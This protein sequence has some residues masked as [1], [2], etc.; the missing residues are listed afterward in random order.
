MPAKNS[1][2]LIDKA[3]RNGFGTIVDPG[4]SGTISP[5]VASY[6]NI[7][8]VTTAGAESRAL[9]AASG[10]PP[11]TRMYVILNTDG[12]DLSITGSADGTIVLDDAGEVA[13]FIVS[14]AGTTNEWRRLLA[15][16]VD[17]TLDSV[18]LG[19]NDPINF[20]DADDISIAW[21]ATLLAITQAAANSAIDMGVDGAG[22]DVIFRGDTAGVSMTWDQS[23]DSLI[24]TDN[25]KAVFGT[26]SDIAITWNATNL[27]ITQAAAN[28]SI[29]MGV[30]GAG[31]DVIFRGDTAGVSMTWDQSADSLILTDN[32]KVVF[33]TGSDIAIA[34]N[35]TNLAITQAAANSSIDLGVDGAGIDVIF[36]GDTASQSLT[37][38]QSADDLVMTSAVQ[39]TGAGSTVVPVVPAAAAIQALI[40]DGDITITQFLTTADTTAATITSALP[41]G[42]QAGQLKKTT[43]VVDGGNDWV[44]TPDSMSGGTSATFADVGDFILWQWT[45]AAWLAIDKGN[46]ATGDD[47]PVIA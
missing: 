23:A 31:I 27:A 43:L 47:G 34:W 42:A 11:Y 35:G 20:G 39:I 24:F 5:S 7:C 14:R 19:D 9:P 28:S 30:D 45:G 29:D 1:L 32:G 22:I 17:L 33:G 13:E 8:E 44:I 40:A 6:I 25:G 12:G 38:D 36:R 41:N 10:F 46:M 26:G 21:N 37:W 2:F 18:S 15:A 3:L 16:G 4:A